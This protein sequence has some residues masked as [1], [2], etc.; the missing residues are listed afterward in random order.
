MIDWA[1]TLESKSDNPSEMARTF[2]QIFEHLLN[3][4]APLKKKEG[5]KRV[6][7]MDYL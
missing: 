4:H 1:S 7:S 3:F 6:L 2:H 5:K